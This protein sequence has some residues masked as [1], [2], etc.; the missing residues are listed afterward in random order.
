LTLVALTALAADDQVVPAP[1]V[2]P[3]DCWTYRT[4]GFENRGPI[5]EYEECVTHVD[6]HKEVIIAVA[7]LK[8]SGREIDT[9]YSTEW[10]PRTSVGGAI[11]TSYKSPRARIFPLRVG[12][13]YKTEREYSMAF[14]GPNAGEETHVV[15]VVRW[16]DVTVPAGTFRALKI[17]D[18]GTGRRFDASL[19]YTFRSVSWYVP[20]VNR[21]VKSWYEDPS[22]RRGTEL[23]AYRLNK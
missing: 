12:D 13:T 6:W 21:H 9:A 8:G 3:G 20:A 14:I 18:F 2:E 16:E 5:D 4:Q 1:F 19:R 7:K 15:K 23:T 22:F 17:E 11:T 10:I